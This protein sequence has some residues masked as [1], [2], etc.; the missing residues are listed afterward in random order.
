VLFRS[1]AQ[2]AGRNALGII[3]TGMGDDGARGLLEMRKLGATTRAQDEESCVVFGM[4]KEAIACGA[5]EKV[6]SLGQ[7]PREIMLWYQAAHTAA[8][9]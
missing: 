8:A 7:I 1:A 3:M 9:G 5:V 4:P 2:H 6:V